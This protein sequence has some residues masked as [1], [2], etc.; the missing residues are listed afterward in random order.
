MAKKVHIMVG[1]ICPCGGKLKYSE[2]ETKKMTKE[3]VRCA[4]CGRQDSAI[5]MKSDEIVP[6]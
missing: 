4:V 3:T 2:W 1:G 6:W 5:R